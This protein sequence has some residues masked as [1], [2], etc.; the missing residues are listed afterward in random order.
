MTHVS[1]KEEMK[2][3]QRIRYLESSALKPDHRTNVLDTRRWGRSVWTR[4]ELCSVII[5]V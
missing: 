3:D 2:I 1:I 5:E 4:L